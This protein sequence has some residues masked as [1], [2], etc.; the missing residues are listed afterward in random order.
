MLTIFLL[1]DVIS[2]YSADK[3]MVHYIWIMDKITT[4]YFLFR[5]SRKYFK[6]VGTKLGIVIILFHI[7]TKHYILHTIYP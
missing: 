6:K 4:S 2:P 1:Q 7:N 5:T 3:S